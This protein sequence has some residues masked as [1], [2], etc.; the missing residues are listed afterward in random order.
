MKRLLTAAAL[1][2]AFGAIEAEAAVVS[3]RSGYRQAPAATSPSYNYNYNSG[4]RARSRGPFARMMEFERQK[5]A[6]LRQMFWGR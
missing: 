5:N 3:Y 1:I 2:V 6:M 4:Y